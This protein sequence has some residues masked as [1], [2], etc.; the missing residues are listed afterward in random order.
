MKDVFLQQLR[1]F[2][3]FMLIAAVFFCGAANLEGQEVV[4]KTVATVTDGSKTELITLSDLR[5]QLALEPGTQ[6]APAASDDLNRVLQQLINLRIFA[7]E[8]E[9]IPRAAPT[10]VEIDKEIKRVLDLFPSTAAFE[11]RL[12]MVGFDSVRDDNFERMMAQ[13]VAIE[14]YLDFR[15][16]SFIVN[17][18]EDEA[19][20]YRDTFVP[21]YKKRYPGVEAPTLAASRA[22]IN[23]ALTENKVEANIEAFLDEAK[24]RVE[25][26]I[27]SEV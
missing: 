20:Y 23:R 8:A 19:K 22:E 13:R 2:L 26:V 6:L 7:L 4:D 11:G 25:V 3:R 5:W 1:P 17:T 18:S 24:R 27:L 12:R 10:K 15:F 16:R 14:K 9:R 21:D